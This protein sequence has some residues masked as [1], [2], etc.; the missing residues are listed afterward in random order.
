MSSHRASDDHPS[1]AVGFQV[2]NFVVDSQWM[3]EKPPNDRHGG[4]L[5]L[6]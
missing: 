4:A 1:V 6:L 5:R 3:I 2:D